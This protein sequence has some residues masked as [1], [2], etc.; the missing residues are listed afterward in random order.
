VNADPI[1]S[2][3][4]QLREA[5]GDGPATRK[6]VD[7]LFRHVHTLKANAAANGFSDLAAA[8]H[9]FENVLHSMRTRAIAD[10]ARLF[11]VQ[12]SFDV[13]DFDQKFQSL[14]E[15]LSNTGEVISTSPS[16]D[17][18]RP[19]KLKFKILYAETNDAV[20]TLSDIPGL[21]VE[22]ITTASAPHLSDV[23]TSASF[24]SAFEKLSEEI[25]KLPAIP[26][27]D[28]FEQA[29]LAGESAALALNKEV[30]FEVRSHDLKLDDKLSE[31]VRNM[32][33]H[34]VRNAVHHG[35]ETSGKV[36][37]KATNR[38]GQTKITVTDDGRGIDPT[39]I[40]QIFQPGFSTA[41]EIS[42]IS[43]R[44]VGLDVV[45]TAIED[46]GGSIS[47]TSEIG[48]GSTFELTLPSESHPR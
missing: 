31:V 6:V 22:E 11:D 19:G 16:M 32:L 15:T 26:P 14:K 30:E 21:I 48:H 45:K 28:V 2:A 9:E 24:D 4:E 37:I 44:G 34:L 18:E 27:G 41:P 42:E 17:N 5:A 33:V 23:Q 46:A 20:H 13:A 8:A 7:A 47:V 29:V 25:A 39:L 35:I 43:G 1:F 12:A 3:I 38:D 10:G 40:Q 36:L